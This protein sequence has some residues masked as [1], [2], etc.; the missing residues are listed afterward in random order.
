MAF[1]CPSVPYKAI[2]SPPFEGKLWLVPRAW[3]A[4]GGRNM[5]VAGRRELLRDVEDVRVEK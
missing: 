1:A 5:P 3:G 4:R 2:F